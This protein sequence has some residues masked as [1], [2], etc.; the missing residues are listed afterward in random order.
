MA[1][2]SGLAMAAH[3]PAP[4]DGHEFAGTKTYS[5]K[6]DIVANVLHGIVVRRLREEVEKLGFK[7]TRDQFR[8]LYV[9]GSGIV[10]ALFEV[11]TD[12]TTGSVYSAIGQLFFHGGA[13][14]AQR[15]VAVVPSGL[16]RL[17]AGRMSALGIR[18]VS[19]TWA[20][21]VPAFQ[22]LAAALA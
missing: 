15:L 11:K 17:G 9:P 18:V 7:A 20:S 14:A 3:S 10:R 8:D 12:L 5:T 4:L 2:D 21:Q 16:G 19:Y 1:V 13:G 22:G 6:P